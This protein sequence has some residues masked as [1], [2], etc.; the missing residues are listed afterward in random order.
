MV[1]RALRQTPDCTVGRRRQAPGA[2]SPGRGTIS[3]TTTFWGA[4]PASTWIGTQHLFMTGNR[5]QCYL[6]NIVKL[7][8][9][10]HKAGQ[11]QPVAL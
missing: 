1:A 6:V 4:G 11:N 10:V 2:D 7:L 9:L 3:W 8:V 5:G